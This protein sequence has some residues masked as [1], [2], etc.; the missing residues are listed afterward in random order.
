MWSLTHSNQGHS[1]KT[2]PHPGHRAAHTRIFDTTFRT[3]EQLGC[4]QKEPS[5]KK[6]ALCAICSSGKA[7]LNGIW[8]SKRD[9]RFNRGLWLSC[10]CGTAC[11]PI[12]DLRCARISG[13]RSS[14]EQM[15]SS[16]RCRST[17]QVRC[18]AQL[19]PCI[20]SSRELLPSHVR[21]DPN[22]YLSHTLHKQE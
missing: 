17:S 15:V 4:A 21:P 11:C 20:F 7:G 5:P 1:S 6:R 16:R 13:L 8:R 10:S 18:T 14:G 9:A 3:L 2:A 12:S 19:F 22:L